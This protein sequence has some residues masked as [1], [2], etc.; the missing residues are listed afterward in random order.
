MNRLS[1]RPIQEREREQQSPAV[2]A[3][4]IATKHNMV[5]LN[6]NVSIACTTPSFES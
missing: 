6:Q 4:V 2:M 5:H 3:A 1:C